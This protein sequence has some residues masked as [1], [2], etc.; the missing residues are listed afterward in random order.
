MPINQESLGPKDR[1]LSRASIITESVKALLLVNGGGA[2]ALLAFLQAIWGKEPELARATLVGIGLMC[3]GLVFA[4]LVQPLRITHSKIVERSGDR[5]TAFWF[6][7]VS[8]Q[9]LSIAA[10]LAAAVYLVWRGMSL[11]PTGA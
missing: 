3:A 6:G 2:V 9:Y 4:L 10:F 7:Y 5:K 1:A 11:L 8:A